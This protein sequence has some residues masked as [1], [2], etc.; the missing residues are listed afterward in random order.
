MDTS[1]PTSYW[2]NKED[3]YT[4]SIRAAVAGALGLEPSH[5]S[6]R[7][8]RATTTLNPMAPSLRADRRPSGSE[9]DVQTATPRGFKYI[10]IHSHMQFFF[11]RYTLERYEI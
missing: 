7:D 8:C 2:K 6:F 11:F 1:N 5:N 9:P 10:S 3:L 4:I